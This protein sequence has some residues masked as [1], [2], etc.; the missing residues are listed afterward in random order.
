VSSV[1]LEQL[2]NSTA[3]RGLDISSETHLSVLKVVLSFINE[4]SSRQSATVV[5]NLQNRTHLYKVQHPKSGDD[6]KLYVLQRF[7]CSTTDFHVKESGD[8]VQ[9][10]VSDSIEVT[11]SDSIN[12]TLA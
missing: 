2:E 10:I 6:A 11:V 5:V 1:V 8:G 9:V 3:S 12:I 7:V 4:V